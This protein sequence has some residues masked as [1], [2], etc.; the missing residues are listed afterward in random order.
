MQNMTNGGS[1]L[2]LSGMARVAG[3]VFSAFAAGAVFVLM[4]T[5]PV[6]F[7]TD[8]GISV[9]S[10]HAGNGNGGGNGGGGGGG[11]GGGN[12][13]AGGNGKGKGKAGDTASVDA[14]SDGTLILMPLEP[15][16]TIAQ[17]TRKIEKRY[18]ADEVTTLDDPNTSIS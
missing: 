17:F 16:I 15:A 1:A 2:K 3:C 10:A 9:N 12:G 5:A 13:N 18:P 11:N 4:A 8:K 7:D 14:D 6:T